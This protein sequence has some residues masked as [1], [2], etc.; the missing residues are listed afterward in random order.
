MVKT[1]N[2]KILFVDD[3]ENILASYKRNLRKKFQISTAPGGQEGLDL[4]KSEG[5]FAVI[6]SDMQMPGMKG[7]EFLAEAN[8][9]NP[10]SIRLMLTGYANINN[11]IDAVNKG[12][13]FRFL[14]KPCDTTTLVQTLNE[15][16]R[17]YKLIYS[18]KELLEKTLKNSIDVLTSILAMINPAAFGRANRVKRY[19][20]QIAQ[21]LNLENVWKLDMA[22]MLS[23]IGFITLPSH[24]LD[25]VYNQET[26]SQK[27]QSMLAEHPAIGGQLIEKIP[28]LETVSE[29]IKRQNIGFSEHAINPETSAEEKFISLGAQ[30]LKVV[31][32]FDEMAFRGVSKTAAMALLKRDQQKYNPKIVDLLEHV[33]INE[34]ERL[35]KLLPI[36]LLKPNMITLQSIMSFNGKMLVA[37]ETEI[38]EPLLQRLFAYNRSVGVV[39]PIKVMI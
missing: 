1:M 23:Q 22:A 15:G 28:R 24:I 37:K 10:D 12:H 5:P 25:K 33:Q 21:K 7:S 29:I 35:S 17:Q 38:T 11:A 32:G 13:I 27:E 19:V 3:D 16:L 20:V 26:L 4:I 39:Q 36:D 9:L 8:K 18:E 6:V 2:E 30:I 31:L 14:T 34:K